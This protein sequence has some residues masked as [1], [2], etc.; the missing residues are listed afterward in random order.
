[1]EGVS[2]FIPSLYHYFAGTITGM[3]FTYPFARLLAAMSMILVFLSHCDTWPAMGQ[4]LV[5]FAQDVNRASLR[6]VGLFQLDIKATV[7]AS[8]RSE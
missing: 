4:R 7:R 8:V 1:M 3:Q 2:S 6:R 5:L